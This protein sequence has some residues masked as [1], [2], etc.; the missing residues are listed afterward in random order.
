MI[1]FD[2]QFC[3]EFGNVAGTLPPDAASVV[4]ILGGAAVVNNSSG[5]IVFGIVA[6]TSGVNTGKFTLN[7]GLN[8]EEG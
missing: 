1:V 7:G 2:P 3:E 4:S 8:T 5:F 6:G